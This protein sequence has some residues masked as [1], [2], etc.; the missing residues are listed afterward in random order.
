MLINL[1]VSERT[2][3]YTAIE[4]AIGQMEKLQREDAGSGDWRPL[5][6]EL[7]RVRAKIALGPENERAW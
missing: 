3:I 6:E 1:D 2:Q 7:R 5:I 4:M